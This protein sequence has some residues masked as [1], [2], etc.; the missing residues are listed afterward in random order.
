MKQPSHKMVAHS[1]HILDVV[2]LHS[3]QLPVTK[4]ND[5]KRNLQNQYFLLFYQ[6]TW[7]YNYAFRS[8]LRIFK[9][10]LL[11]QYIISLS[12]IK[13]KKQKMRNYL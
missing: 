9:W 5:I 11:D 1:L 6:Q 4:Q 10:I 13:N 2:A 3:K 8:K 7:N 12:D